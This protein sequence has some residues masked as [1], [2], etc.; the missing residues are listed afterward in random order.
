MKTVSAFSSLF[1][2]QS[3][4]A[5]FAKIEQLL[6][7]STNLPSA[8]QLNSNYLSLFDYGCWCY[9]PA[10]GFGKG[11]GKPLDAFDTECRKLA[12]N[13][14]CLII[15]TVNNA[16]NACEN[17]E[18]W[19]TSYNLDPAGYMHIFNGNIDGVLDAC[20]TGNAGNVCATNVCKAELKFAAVTIAAAG[21]DGYS[22]SKKHDNGFDAREEGKCE[23]AQR[24]TT[25]DFERECCGSYPEKFP[26]KRTASRGCCNDRTFDVN[27]LQCCK[28]SL[29]YVG[30]ICQ[31]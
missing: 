25:E 6:Q 23:A 14:E 12:H 26:Y 24:D 7:N 3:A 2:A 1:L 28:S 31:V 4:L 8:R 20:I 30:D 22:A 17:E 29:T 11:R 13:Y 21:M 18:P 5:D 16:E 9:N 19:T 10:T 27:N 15:E